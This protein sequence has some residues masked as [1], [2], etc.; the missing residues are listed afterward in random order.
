[1]WLSKPSTIGYKK[2]LNRLVF[3][4]LILKYVV[5]F[6]LW[7]GETVL[8]SSVNPRVV[9]CSVQGDD[10]CS[11]ALPAAFDTDILVTN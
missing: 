4:N 9:V 3:I 7:R 10:S 5:S 2:S 1:M 8:V 6:L 11:P